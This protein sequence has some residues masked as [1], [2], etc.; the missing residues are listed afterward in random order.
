MSS[1]DARTS[2]TFVSLS[3]STRAFLPVKL[4]FIQL[5]GWPVFLTVVVVVAAS[6]L[7]LS[8]GMAKLA[9]NRSVAQN[10]ALAVMLLAFVGC[11]LLG[12]VAVL[13]RL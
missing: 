5:S 13:S 10:A 4:W 11:V 9:T 8:V 2:G 6:M 7:A 1:P 12:V 3:P